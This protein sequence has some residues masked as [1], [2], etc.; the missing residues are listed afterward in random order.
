MKDH[1]TIITPRSNLDYE[2]VAIMECDAG[3]LESAERR[4]VN[5][6]LGHDNWSWGNPI[7]ETEFGTYQAFGIK[8]IKVA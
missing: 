4:I 3:M 5:R 1:W 8:E 6:Q 7:S 2:M